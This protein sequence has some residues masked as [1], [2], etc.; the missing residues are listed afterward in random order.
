MK[1]TIVSFLVLSLILLLSSCGLLYIP[2][3]VNA[4]VIT[5]KNEK[6]ITL[7]YGSSAF[8][9]NAAYSPWDKIA[10]ITNLNY[11]HDTETNYKNFELGIGRYYP[12]HEHFM[13]DFYLGGGFG[14]LYNISQVQNNTYW[15]RSKYFYGF[16]QTSIN[17][18][19]KYATIGIVGKFAFPYLSYNTD[20]PYIDLKNPIFF[21]YDQL[22]LNILVGYKFIYLNAQL[23]VDYSASDLF[24]YS[25]L[26]LPLTLDFGLT[27]KF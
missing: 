1:R 15:S 27:F 6:N 8:S 7:G 23:G 25:K 3:K 20:N 19:T 12:F 11:N 9:F 16:G 2:N 21:N 17:Y 24:I 22:L 4:P 26:I 14:S 13:Y 10:L 18:V 5:K